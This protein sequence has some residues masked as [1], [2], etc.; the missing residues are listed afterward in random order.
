MLDIDQSVSVQ[1]SEAS[2]PYDG[3]VFARFDALGSLGSS[4]EPNDHAASFMAAEI[5][6]DAYIQ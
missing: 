2:V 6:E 1:G 3:M 4:L 5:D